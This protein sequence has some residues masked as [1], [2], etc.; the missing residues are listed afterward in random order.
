MK[1]GQK[2]YALIYDEYNLQMK[3]KRIISI[4]KT[5]ENADK[6]LNKRLKKMGKKVWECNTRI[7][8]VKGNRFKKGE[9]ITPVD[10]ETWGPNDKIPAGEYSTDSD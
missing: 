6:A 3:Q 8:W 1:G 4:H 7:V 10:F 9:Q 5:R 2:M